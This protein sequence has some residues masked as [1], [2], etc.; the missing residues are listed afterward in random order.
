MKENYR[1]NLAFTLLLITTLSLFVSLLSCSENKGISKNNKSQ[2]NQKLIVIGFDGMDYKLLKNLMSEGKLPTFKKLSE[3][4]DFKPLGTSIPPQSPVAW[5]NFITGMN[6]GGHG[7]FDF[8]HRDPE[9]MFPYLSTSKIE[10]AQKTVTI[11]KW[12]IPLSSGEVKLL[13][14]G[15]A[16][17]EYLTDDGIQTTIFRVPANFP[18]TT[19]TEANQIS[20]MGTP[21]IQGTYGTFSYFTDKP[22]EEYSDISGG[23]IFPVRARNNVVTAKLPGPL[24][25]F[26]KNAPESKVKFKVFIDPDNPVAKIVVQ[27]NEIILQEGE[28]SDWVKIKYSLVPLLQSTTGIVRFYIKELHPDFKMYVS[29]VNIDPSAPALPIS[30]P[31][32]YAEEL[33]NEIGLFYTQ[34]IPEDTKALSEEVLTDNEFLEQTNLVMDEEMKMLEYE[35]ERF[36]SGMLFFYIGRVDQLSHM[37]WR[38]MDPKHPAYDSATELRQVI[39]NAYIEMDGILAQVLEKVDDNTTIIV[40]SDHGF[41]PFYR[42]FNLNT[43]LSKEGYITLTNDEEGEFFQNVD[44]SSTQAYGVGFNGLYINL[45]YREREG[46]IDSSNREELLDEISEKLLKIRD[47]KNGEQVISRVYRADEV[48]SGPNLKDA[49][50]LIVGYNAGYRASWETVLG[51]FPKEVLRDNTEKW[52]GDH[53]MEA[54]LV[55]GIVL[56]NK[57]IPSESPALYDIAPTILSE[58]GIPRQEGMI[59]NSIFNSDKLEN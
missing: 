14:Q 2:T 50:D 41:A 6:P 28:W 36:Q 29:P 47:P 51:S 12:V 24:N 59:G 10:Q 25:T 7:I 40:L 56:S 52:S 57:K 31:D 38:T 17:W 9:T 20:G 19:N 4:G 21:D 45:K 46:I 8:I 1:I 5:S 23:E 35:L 3:E 34:G 32:E 15:K 42:A 26:K 53:L 11:G 44:W 58:F 30:T 37:F 54:Q 33:A 39:E 55:P 49:P 13:R 43:W 16:F 27:D 48:Y 18:T 22:P